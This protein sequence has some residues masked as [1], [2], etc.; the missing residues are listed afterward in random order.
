[1]NQF[2]LAFE[3]PNFD[4]QNQ[5]RNKAFLVHSFMRRNRFL[6]A[7]FAEVEKFD[8]VGADRSI[9]SPAGNTAGELA[10]KSGGMPPRF[11]S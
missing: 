9:T 10:G 7:A 3:P 1:L 8:G 6:Q 2:L 4:W 5:S 11:Y